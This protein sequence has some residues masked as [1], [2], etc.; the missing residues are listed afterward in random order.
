MRNSN[1]NLSKSVKA[2]YDALDRLKQNGKRINF[3]SVSLEAGR[4]RGSIKGNSKQIND[5]KEAILNA[6][7]EQQLNNYRNPSQHKLSETNRVKENYKI[8]YLTLKKI[9]NTQSIQLASALFELA[10][11]KIEIEDILNSADNV[12]DI[13]NQIK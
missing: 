4:G 9:Y 5:L 12:I 1:T 7:K 3:D 6:K 8:K 11:L 10:E 2:Y 13:K